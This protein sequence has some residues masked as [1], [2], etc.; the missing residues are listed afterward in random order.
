MGEKYK[1][2]S[3]ANL[4]LTIEGEKNVLQIIVATDIW[5]VLALERS[6]EVFDRKEIPGDGIGAHK[7]ALLGKFDTPHEALH[8]AER[9]ANEWRKTEMLD[10]AVCACSISSDGSR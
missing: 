10:A 1:W 5:T 9:F 6:R 7:H 2:I 8:V 4:S 3:I